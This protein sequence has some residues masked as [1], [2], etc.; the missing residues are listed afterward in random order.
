MKRWLLCCA[1]M[2]LSMAALA[3]SPQDGSV[4]ASMLVTGTIVEVR[5]GSVASCTID[6]PEKLPPAVGSLLTSAIPTW[7]FDP[8]ATDGKA[9]AARVPIA[10]R[11]VA[12]TLGEDKVRLEIEGV[13]FGP[14]DHHPGIAVVK[15]EKPVYPPAA[16]RALVYG[17]VYLAMRVDPAGKVTDAAVQQVDMG[18]V[19]RDAE[20][21]HWRELLGR[22]S[23]EAASQWVFT[24]ASD[25]TRPYRI[26][27][28]SFTFALNA[29]GGGSTKPAYGQWNVYEPGPVQPVPWLDDK[30]ATGGVDA[31]PDGDIDLVGQGLHVRAQQSRI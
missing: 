19:K 12:T 1:G 9:T 5:D 16:E 18:V 24:P 11:V 8:M 29:I 2:V 30:Q 26:V 17:T 3:A 15:Q 25:A 31:L 14:Q 7:K 27:R 20:L 28:T 22:A 10:V 21:N 13:H 23:R 6:H 4:R